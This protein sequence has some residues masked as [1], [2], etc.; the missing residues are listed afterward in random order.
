MR[1][2]TVPRTPRTE[3]HE[4]RRCWS[5]I[6]MQS[7]TVTSPVVRLERRL[8]DERVF[9]VAPRDAAR[10][11]RRARSASGRAPACRAARRSTRRNRSGEGTAS[12]WSRRGRRARPSGNR[13]SAHSPRSSRRYQW[14][15]PFRRNAACR[16]RSPRRD[17]ASPRAIDCQPERPRPMRDCGGR[18][19]FEASLHQAALV[20]RPTPP[21]ILVAE[22]SACTRVPCCENRPSTSLTDVST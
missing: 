2:R 13:R 19:A 18:S 5:R 7:M 16:S 17:S 10:R 15:S 3:P 8:Q 21:A 14:F 6:G 22:V 20:V 4:V 12:R 11:L 9:A 1:I